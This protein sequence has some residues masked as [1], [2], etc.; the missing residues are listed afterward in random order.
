MSR[1]AGPPSVSGLDPAR[2]VPG[3]RFS[4]VGSRLPLGDVPSGVT[5]GGRAALV[6]FAS[7]ERLIVEAPDPLEG[8]P[9]DV[10]LAALPG[11]LAV[12]DV[13]TLLATGFH[14]VDSPVIDRAGRSYATYSG[15]RGQ[16]VAV[17][18]FRIDPAGVREPLVSGIVNAT[19]M[20]LDREATLY[21][22]SRFAGTVSKVFDDGRFEVVGSGLGR[23]CGLA[24]APDGTL[25]VGDRSGTIFHLDLKGAT[26][27]FAS[28]PPSVAAFHL[29]MGPDQA[30]YVT[31]PT[32]A[33]RDR[34]YRLNASG[35]VESLAATF[36][37]PQGLAFSPDGVLHIVEALAGWNG[38][39]RVRPDLAPE[40]VVAG[41]SLIG[42]TFSP[43]GEMVVASDESLYG[44]AI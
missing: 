29:A 31:A 28:L 25:F 5:V 13:G 23:A 3:A 22:S 39:Y 16:E 30:L 1:G 36:G 27:T 2:V 11:T 26:R 19:S 12:L 21:V 33:P 32:L 42:I 18:I 41:R 10:E 43:A 14:Q 8:G 20:A 6:V 9:T 35:H 7:G 38:V 17:S 40:L 34:V 4:I 24:F 37:R 44:F 15:A